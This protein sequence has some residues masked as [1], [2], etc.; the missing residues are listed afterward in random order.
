[1][2][3]R[4]IHERAYRGDDYA[5]RLKRRIT[6]CGVGAL[7]S[8]LVDTLV[9][10]GVPA[11]KVIDKDRVEASNTC[12]Q[13]YGD[14]DVGAMKADAMKNR[15]FRHVG[16]EIE[17]FNKELTVD[18]VAKVFKGSSLVVDMFDNTPSRQLVQ[19]ACRAAK[20]PCIHGGMALGFGQVTWDQYYRVPATTNDEDV[21]DYPLSRNLV[22]LVVAI[23]AEEILDFCL[24]PQPRLMNWA[25]TLKDL[26]IRPLVLA[27]IAKTV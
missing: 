16:V 21:C 1:M 19:T 12:T 23:A 5:Q 18:N 3:D 8:N 15:V 2:A 10:I 9:R 25:V 17:S 24:S 11:I 14:M 26:K 4:F 22:V 20:I 13:V 6:V 7:G 27:E